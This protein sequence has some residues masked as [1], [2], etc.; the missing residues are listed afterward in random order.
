M[1]ARVAWIVWD[2]WRREELAPVL[3]SKAEAERERKT[4]ASCWPDMP[5]GDG[6]RFEVREIELPGE[7]CDR[8]NCI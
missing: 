2:R 6:P 4:A 1:G 5:T 3:A 8:C 7:G